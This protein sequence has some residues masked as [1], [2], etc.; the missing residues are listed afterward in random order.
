MQCEDNSKLRIPLSEVCKTT[1]I[2]CVPIIGGKPTYTPQPDELPIAF[3]PSSTTLWLFSCKTHDWVAFQKFKL[4]QLSKMNLDNIRNICEVLNIAV[5]YDSGSAHVQ[6]TVTLA[7]FGEELLK[8]IQLKTRTLIVE[9]DTVKV[10]VDGLDKLPPYF[11]KGNNIWFEGGSGTETDPLRVATYDPICKWPKRTQAQVNASSDKFLGACIDGDMVRVPFIDPPCSYPGLSQEQVDAS[12]NKTLIACVDGKGAKVP[13]IESDPPICELPLVTTSQVSSAGNNA[14]MAV[15][16]SGKSSRM[17]IPSGMF[18]PEYICV[19]KVTEKPT[20]PPDFGTGPIRM[21]CN[22]ELFVWLCNENRWEGVIPDHGTYRKLDPNDVANI[23]ENL[24]IPAWYPAGSDECAQNVYLTVNQLFDIFGG[25][26]LMK[27]MIEIIANDAANICK[28]PEAPSNKISS[29]SVALCV[30]G[31]NAK[32]TVSNLANTIS[33]SISGNSTFTNTI[34]EKVAASGKVQSPICSLSNVNSTDITNAGTNAKVAMCVNGS[35]KQATV[36]ALGT[37]MAKN[38]NFSDALVNNNSFVNGLAG[39]LSAGGTVQGS[40]CS[41]P[42]STKSSM[43]SNWD[44]IT[45]PICEN[46]SSKRISAN[47]FTDIILSKYV[48]EEPSQ[49]CKLP[50]SLNEYRV[51]AAGKGGDRTCAFS[52]VRMNKFRDTNVRMAIYRSSTFNFVRGSGTLTSNIENSERGKGVGHIP[53]EVKN[54]SNCPARVEIVTSVGV[55]SAFR[56]ESYS[57]TAFA[58]PSLEEYD[59]YENAINHTTSSNYGTQHAVA[60]FHTKSNSIYG[61]DWMAGDTPIVRTVPVQNT[62]AAITFTL[63]PNNSRTYYLQFFIVFATTDEERSTFGANA[64]D[65][66]SLISIVPNLQISARSTV[67]VFRGLYI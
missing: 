51:V 35:A 43:N 9:R 44:K 15:C 60:S 31:S 22:N 58:I 41:L 63:Q 52:N 28:F 57:V 34:S 23:N 46:G 1:D 45:V 18:V 24:R 33:S 64:T 40:I 19:P 27:E 17:P 14:T 20:S 54:T 4:D 49:A 39:K 25:S 2:G 55:T 47:T 37:S 12:T 53:F 29:A 5:W 16:L 56:N 38:S 8:C 30:D 32:T 62:S 42:T 50:F 6:G 7:Q 48:P 67:K 21:G 59:T 13:Y 65:D 11:V 10:W 36:A 61:G 26:D 66:Y 3:D